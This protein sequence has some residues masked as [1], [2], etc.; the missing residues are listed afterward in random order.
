M[1]NDSEVVQ[2]LLRR[3]SFNLNR[4]HYIAGFSDWLRLELVYQFGGLWLDASILMNDARLIT[5]MH[6]EA[7]EKRFEISGFHHNMFQTLPQFPIVESWAFMAPPRST[8]VRQWRD[9]HLLALRLGPY[10]YQR[11]VL[12]AN[13]ADPQLLYTIAGTYLTIHVC[14]QVVLQTLRGHQSWEDFAQFRDATTKGGPLTLQQNCGQMNFW[15]VGDALADKRHRR[16]FSLIK[17]TAKHRLWLEAS[18]SLRRYLGEKPLTK[19]IFLS[20]I[21]IVILILTY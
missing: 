7:C 10:Y 18:V 19:I 6:D 15:C 2:L 5:E 1:H 14:A 8:F 4:F 13:R 3:D 21:L 20:I 9:E 12:E 11:A 16:N 17:L